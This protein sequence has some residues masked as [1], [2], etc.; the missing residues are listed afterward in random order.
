MYVC[1]SILLIIL[2]GKRFNTRQQPLVTTNGAVYYTTTPPAP[3]SNIPIDQFAAAVY[4]QGNSFILFYFI[5]FYC[6]LL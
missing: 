5:R 6:I 1:F 3:I 4:P 2:Y